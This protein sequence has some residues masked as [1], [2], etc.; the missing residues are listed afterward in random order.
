M[1]KVHEQLDFEDRRE[2]YEKHRLA[3]Y[4]SNL[5]GQMSQRTE[6]QLKAAAALK[7][8]ENW[9]LAKV[10]RAAHRELVK[11]GLAHGST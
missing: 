3:D 1:R 4:S 6:T 7:D 11:R 8:H 2:K 9:D 10:G 5:T